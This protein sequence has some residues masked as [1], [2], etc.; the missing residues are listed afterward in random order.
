VEDVHGGRVNPDLIEVPRQKQIPSRNEQ[1]RDS[2]ESVT[3]GWS[4]GVAEVV[5][6]GADIGNRQR[7]PAA[8]VYWTIGIRCRDRDRT[9]ARRI[10]VAV[11]LSQ[12]EHEERRVPD[13]ARD[14]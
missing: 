2:R 10:T 5:S 13:L 12:R 6:Y 7:L 9:L 3:S 1:K 4:D 14:R 11:T 8:Y